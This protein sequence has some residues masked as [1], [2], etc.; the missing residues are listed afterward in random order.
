MNFYKYVKIRT[1]ETAEISPVAKNM[2]NPLQ[3]AQ[4]MVTIQTQDL[5][6]QKLQNVQKALRNLEKS[7]D[8][9]AMQLV[10]QIQKELDDVRMGMYYLRNMNE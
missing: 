5:I 9:Q 1:N 8:G 4:K 2:E 10:Y 7:M 3:M 6:S